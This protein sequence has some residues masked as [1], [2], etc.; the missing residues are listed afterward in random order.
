MDLKKG[1]SLYHAF[2]SKPLESDK[3]LEFFGEIPKA[4]C[5]RKGARDDLRK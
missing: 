2:K 5:R 1:S 3:S 4:D